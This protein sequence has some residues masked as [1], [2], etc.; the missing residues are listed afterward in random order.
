M[1]RFRVGIIVGLF[2]LPMTTTALAQDPPID[3]VPNRPADRWR[4]WAVTEGENTRLVVEGVYSNG[5]PGVVA[6]VTPATPQG[7]NPKILILDV[8]VGTLPGVWPAI[9]TPIPASYVAKDYKAGTYNSIH[10]RYPNGTSV[11]IDK[12]IDTGAGPKLK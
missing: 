1:N 6:V 2:L 7:I 4:A 12:I 11:M 8:K 10:I 5:G 3:K 9:L